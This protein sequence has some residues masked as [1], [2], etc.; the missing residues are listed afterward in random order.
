MA[1]SIQSRKWLILKCTFLV[2]RQ[3]FFLLLFFK[4]FCCPFS[5]FVYYFH[6]LNFIRE[7]LKQNTWILHS[8]SQYYAEKMSKSLRTNVTKNIYCEEKNS[9]KKLSQTSRPLSFVIAFYKHQMIQTF[10]FL[11]SYTLIK[12]PGKFKKKLFLQFVC[13]QLI[14]NL[15]NYRFSIQNGACVP[16]LFA[17]EK[18]Y[19]IVQIHL[20]EKNSDKYSL[21]RFGS[22]KIFV[23]YL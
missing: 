13:E 2:L 10:T 17:S 20:T 14:V 21:K 5:A 16:D 23:K 19:W 8:Y 11:S 9:E 18:N 3:V 7:H 12:M 6:L 22:P 15:T 4:S 1:T